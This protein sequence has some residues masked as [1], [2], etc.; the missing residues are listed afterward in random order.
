M[1][2]F[3]AHPITRLTAI[4]QRVAAG[5]MTALA[6]VE[7]RDEIGTLSNAFNSM[8]QQLGRLIRGLEARG[9]ALETSAQV[10]HRLS[11]ILDQQQLVAEVVEQVQQGFNYYHVH[12]YLVDDAG[13][14]LAMA[15]GTGEAGRAMLAGRHRIPWGKGLV[16]RAAETRETVL[17][18]DVSQEEGWLPNPLL[19]D[20]RSEIAVPIMAG[21]R[22]LGVLDVQHN[23]VAGLG[24]SDA[25]LLGSIAGQAA[26]A[27]QNTRLFAETQQRAE[28]EAR[29]NQISQR[30]QST[31]TVESALQIAVRELGQALGAHE[32]S[33]RLHSAAQPGNGHKAE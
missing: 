2:R 21:E 17:V 1:A 27:L 4:A 19:P 12:I 26:V 9:R 20:T 25:D 22:V 31:T 32:T 16:G 23:L 33:V 14:T 30:I 5:D 8:T 24:E 29:L 3:L 15:G 13:Q 10:S 7:S 18:P 6:R 28:R 11:T